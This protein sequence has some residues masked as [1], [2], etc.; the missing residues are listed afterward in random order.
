MTLE[1]A[2]ATK[3]KEYQAANES[4]LKIVK[5]LREMREPRSEKAFM[6]C[7]IEKLCRSVSTKRNVITFGVNYNGAVSYTHLTL[8]TKA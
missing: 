4:F 6:L 5:R 8:P 7:D 3:R 2:A 1:N